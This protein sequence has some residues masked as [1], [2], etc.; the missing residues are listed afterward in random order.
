MKN[1]LIEYKGYYASINISVADSCLFGKVEFIKDSIV[2]GADTL[3]EL[4]STFHAELDD[5]LELCAEVGKQPDKTM[6]GSFNVRIGEELHKKALIKSKCDGVALNDV[7]KKAVS[8]Y[9]NDTSEI[10]HHVNVSVKQEPSKETVT[11]QPF[12]LSP[13]PVWTPSTETTNEHH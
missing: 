4:I 1:E 10:H 5:Y 13:Y 2:F 11:T 8:Q 3:P 6:T 7:I 9:V 12:D